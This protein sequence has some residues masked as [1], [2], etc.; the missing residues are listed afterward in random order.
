VSCTFIVIAPADF[1][2]TVEINQTSFI[3]NI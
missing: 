1:K 3:V 2:I